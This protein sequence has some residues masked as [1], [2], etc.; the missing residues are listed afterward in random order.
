MA[1]TES[2]EC[3]IHITFSFLIKCKRPNS[4]DTPQATTITKLHST[5]MVLT[6]NYT[7]EP[8]DIIMCVLDPATERWTDYTVNMEPQN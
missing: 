1:V 5:V 7:V 3:S 8:I 2:F 6:W 4:Y